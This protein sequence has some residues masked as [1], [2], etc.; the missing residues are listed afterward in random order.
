MARR[1]GE[2]GF[3]L[4]CLYEFVGEADGGV[5]V[6][7]L[8]RERLFIAR[9]GRGV[10]LLFGEKIA[11]GRQDLVIVRSLREGEL[12]FLFGFGFVGGFGGVMESLGQFV[13]GRRGG[14]D[15]P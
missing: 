15:R 2:G 10:V 12:V 6:L 8:D 9:D 3:G 13:V 14:W 4:T 7:G 11:E 5:F 1:R